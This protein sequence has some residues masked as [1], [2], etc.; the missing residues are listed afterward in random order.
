MK[1]S[2]Y[3]PVR[4]RRASSGTR[5]GVCGAAIAM[6]EPSVRANMRAR[7]RTRME[8]PVH[9]TAAFA[10]RYLMLRRTLPIVLAAL[11]IAPALAQTG[12][13]PAQRAAAQAA[14]PPYSP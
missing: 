4:S 11:V 10:R 13:R 2:R 12:Q 5:T 9:Y 6:A 14:Q 8:G 1:E 7:K 3:Q